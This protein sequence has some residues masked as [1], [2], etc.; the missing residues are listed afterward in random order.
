[1]SWRHY[2]AMLLGAATGVAI[3]VALH[4]YADYADA[5]VTESE[6]EVIYA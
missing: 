1:M 6:G 4:R 3:A 5:N 2:V